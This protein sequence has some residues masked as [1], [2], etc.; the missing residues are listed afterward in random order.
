MPAR[1]IA[2]IAA[3]EF[4]GLMRDRLP[5][6]I[7]L[8]ALLWGL[9]LRIVPPVAAGAGDKILIDVGVGAIGL[10]SALVVAFTGAEVMARDIERRTVL[11]VLSQPISRAALVLGKHAGLV[12]VAIALVAAMALLYFGGLSLVGV[13]YPL[14]QLSVALAFLVLELALL[15]GVALALG[16]FAGSLLAALLTLGAYVMGHASRNLL[17]LGELSDNPGARALSQ[18]LYLLLPDLS[19]LNWRNEAAYEL[20]PPPPELA[21]H[22][23]Y[24]VA[25]TGAVLAIAIAILGRREF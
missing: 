1:R 18:A 16:A 10:L 21:G 4:R 11:L 23:L 8:F 3:K 25:Y 14:G 20:L 17:E 13:A 9:A 24:G 6:C 5:Y 7:G 2:A 19:R 22:A 15:A 12:S